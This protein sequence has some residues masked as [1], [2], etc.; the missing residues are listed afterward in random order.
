MNNK[1]ST[2]VE[3]IAAVFGVALFSGALYLG[4]LVIRALQKY[5]GA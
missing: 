3:V 1:G 2:I 5:V 4:Y